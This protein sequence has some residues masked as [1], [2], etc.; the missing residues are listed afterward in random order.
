MP[1]SNLPKK[2]GL[3]NEL[4]E[5]GLK[6]HLIGGAFEQAE[7]MPKKHSNKPT[8]LALEI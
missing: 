1:G 2:R 5:K 6:T 8:E 4:T 7:L 3:F